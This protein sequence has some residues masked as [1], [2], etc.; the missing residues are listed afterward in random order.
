MLA[1]SHDSSWLRR[2]RYIGNKSGMIGSSNQLD[3]G[4]TDEGLFDKSA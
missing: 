1:N 4:A 3:K 2:L